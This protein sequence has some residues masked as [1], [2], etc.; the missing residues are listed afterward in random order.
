MRPAVLFVYLLGTVG[1]ALGTATL[2]GPVRWITGAIRDQR[3]GQGAEDWAVRGLILLLGLVALGIAVALYEAHRDAASRRVRLGIPAGTG[4]LALA[5]LGLWMNP[6]LMAGS[7]APMQDGGARFVFGPY[8]TR[9]RLEDLKERGFAGVITLL[10]PAVVPFEPRL[11]AEEMDA[12]REVGIRVVHTPMLPWVSQNQASLQKIRSLAESGEGRWYVHCY[13]GKDRVNVVRR[14]LEEMNLP[15]DAGEARAGARRL[16]D[17]PAFERGSIYHLPDSVHV[18]PLPTDEEWFGYLLSGQVK[19]LLSL[20]DPADPEDAVWVARERELA[21]QYRLPL[22]VFPIPTS[23]YDPARALEAAR[24]AKAL[25]RPLV[26]H[27]FRTHSA[28]TEAFV[29]AYRTGLP[30]LPPTLFQE[31]MQRGAPRVLGANVAVGPR[32]AGAEL[33]GYLWPRGVRE[34][35]YLGSPESPDARR[36]RETAASTGLR[37]RAAPAA[38][39]ALHRLLSR[40]GPWY[41]YGPGLAALE[42]ELERRLDPGLPIPLPAR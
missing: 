12:A 17:V 1:F 6:R 9:E 39:E 5:A 35:V 11:L 15:V 22:E 26:V 13:L 29:Q 18:T 33:G 7:E 10:H 3:M 28:S 19:Q 38:G 21:A 4:L 31:P 42:P 14:L 20:L 34:V 16:E 37:W 41:L 2:M 24:R 36:D 32:P 40:G 27:A 25:P 30:P 23:P 8:P